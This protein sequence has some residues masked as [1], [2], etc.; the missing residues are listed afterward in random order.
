ME[1]PVTA[2]AAMLSS[3]PAPRQGDNHQAG[4]RQPAK[5]F[6]RL[7]PLKPSPTP[8]EPHF[9]G[10]ELI[11]KSLNK[12]HTDAAKPGI[13]QRAVLRAGN[14]LINGDDDD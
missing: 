13:K 5:G 10:E 14:T 11:P 4:A 6:P 3:E 9:V 1:A 8:E 2:M 12:L 7:L